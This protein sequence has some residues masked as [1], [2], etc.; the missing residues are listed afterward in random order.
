[1]CLL[2]TSFIFNFFVVEG[3]SGLVSLFW[4]DYN[5]SFHIQGI[6]FLQPISVLHVYSI[7]TEWKKNTFPQQH[8]QCYR[9]RRIYSQQTNKGH[10]GC[11]SRKL[12]WGWSELEECLNFS[13]CWIRF[14]EF[15]RN[16]FLFVAFLSSPPLLL[17]SKRAE[18]CVNM[19]SLTKN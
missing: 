18:F 3:Q 6:F 9:S 4:K 1:M 12:F 8:A 11:E 13:Q 14:F 10:S 2:L 5:L 7:C 17:Y 19:T 15:L 16:C